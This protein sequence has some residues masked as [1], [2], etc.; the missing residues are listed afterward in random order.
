MAETATKAMGSK[1]K[2]AYINIIEQRL[3]L[4]FGTTPKE[5]GAT[6]ALRHGEGEKMTAFY[7]D[8]FVMSQAVW[9][10]FDY[11]RFEG[12]RITEPQLMTEK[13]YKGLYGLYIDGRLQGIGGKVM[14]KELIEKMKTK[15]RDVKRKEIADYTKLSLDYITSSYGQENRDPAGVLKGYGDRIEALIKPAGHLKKIW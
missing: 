6:I 10:T 7:R 1:V 11:A 15:A 8:M 12:R 2:Q 5:I 9:D 14:S 3:S 4:N 13:E